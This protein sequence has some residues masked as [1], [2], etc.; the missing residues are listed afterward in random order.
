MATLG[1]SARTAGADLR[2]F[3]HTYEYSTVP[4]GRTT[5]ELWHTQSR[6]TPDASSAQLY[7]GILEVEH[8][9]T[10]HLDVGLYTVLEQIEAGPLTSEALRLSKAKL[11]SRYRIGE[12]GDLPIDTLLF[13]ELAKAFGDSVYEIRGKV[14][15]ARD[16]GDLT[17]AANAIG[18]VVIGKDVDETTLELGWAAGAT[19]QLHPKLR[20]GVETWGVLEDRKAYVDVGPALS[21][22]P[23]ST[24]WTAITLGFSLTERETVESASHGAFSA[25]VIVGL[26]L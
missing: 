13:L 3:S 15:G 6:A 5:V 16:F 7:E 10:E 21:Y 26:E 17:L 2:S 25:R 11:E 12:R 22:A 14:I 19:Y 1:V 23:S 18:G 9:I 24:F 8:G 20:L 4:E